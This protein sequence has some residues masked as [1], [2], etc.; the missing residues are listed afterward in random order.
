MQRD[1]FTADFDSFVQVQHFRSSSPTTGTGCDENTVDKIKRMNSPVKCV[2]ASCSARKHLR[3]QANTLLSKTKVCE[4]SRLAVARVS[5]ISTKHLPAACRSQLCTKL[6]RTCRA[7]PGCQTPSAGST[8][9]V[10]QNCSN[11]YKPNSHRPCAQ[12]RK[13]H[14]MPE[15]QGFQPKATDCTQGPQ[16]THSCAASAVVSFHHVKENQL[17]S[18]SKGQ[19]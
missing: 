5:N 4:G 16:L 11:S 10:Y 6:H 9:K 3:A 13:L 7:V 8:S 19:K 15:R 12:S 14:I 2:H 18:R 17:G 1:L